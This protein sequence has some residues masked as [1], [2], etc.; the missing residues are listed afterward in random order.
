M[1]ER[2]FGPLRSVLRPGERSDA[3]SGSGSDLGG[4]VE[5]SFAS[6]GRV[7]RQSGEE[8][9]ERD[10][11]V[12]VNNSPWR[13]R[14]VV[15]QVHVAVAV[16]HGVAFEISRGVERKSELIRRTGIGVALDGNPYSCSV[17]APWIPAC[18]GVTALTHL[19]SF[20]RRRESMD[21]RTHPSR[22]LF[23]RSRRRSVVGVPVRCALR[24]GRASR[25]PFGCDSGLQ[26]PRGDGRLTLPTKRGEPA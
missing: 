26:R 2:P 20:P 12:A 8:A 9:S 17:K 16:T 15:S 22:N 10:E 21:F 25:A 14:S 19:M 1:F 3:L 23:D 4:I 18:A 7:R 11:T 13:R 5:D 24:P 6:S